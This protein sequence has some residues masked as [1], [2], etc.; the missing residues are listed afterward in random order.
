MIQIIAVF[1]TSNVVLVNIATKQGVQPESSMA[2]V[3]LLVK[4]INSLIVTVK[5]HILIMIIPTAVDVATYASLRNC[6]IMVSVK[7]AAFLDRMK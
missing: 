6:A 4:S 2:M 3:P 1:V 5:K 7:S